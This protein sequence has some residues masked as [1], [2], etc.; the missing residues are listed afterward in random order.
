MKVNI[1]QQPFLLHI[2]DISNALTSIKDFKILYWS[3]RHDGGTVL[4]VSLLTSYDLTSQTYE[5]KP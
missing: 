2:I 5:V 4:T 1:T 3:T